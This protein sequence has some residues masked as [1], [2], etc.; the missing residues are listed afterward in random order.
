MP[1]NPHN[2]ETIAEGYSLLEGP[3]WRDGALFFSDFYTHR[4]MKLQDDTI[5]LVC[6]VPAQPSGLGFTPD[7]DLLV[8][9]MLDHRLLRLRG[10]TL[11]V[12]A[13]ISDF[14]SGPANDLVV[15]AKGRVYIG[16]FGGAVT[17]DDP[18][19]PTNI[20]IVDTDGTVRVAASDV[21]FPNGMALT[22]DGKVLV[23]AETFVGRLTAFDVESDGLLSNRRVWAQFSDEPDYLDIERA[24]AELPV[25]PDGIALDEE[26]CIWVAN[27]KGSIVNRVREG[28]KIVDQVDVHDTAVY[29]VALG[30]SDLR[31]LFLCCAPTLGTSDPVVARRASLRKTRVSVPGL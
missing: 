1:T 24:T 25:V 21:V 11:E 30:G 9:S 5:E 16:N 20:V 22:P 15:D 4:V 10:G 26:G 6:Q 18:I 7:G 29:A 31:T 3:R 28:G 8:S 14:C 12:V 23:V 17:P 2:V 13:D 27:A 19:K